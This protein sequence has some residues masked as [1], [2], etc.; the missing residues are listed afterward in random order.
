[1]TTGRRASAE[2]ADG[3]GDVGGRGG[4]GGGGDGRRVGAVLEKEVD[5]DGEVDGSFAARVGDAEGALE[6]ARDLG[7]A[8]RLGGPFADG[9]GHR[10]LVDVLEGLAIAASYWGGC[11]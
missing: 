10:D 2:K 4:G 8:G 3:G 7:G 5:G 9:G 6:V 11:R 1:M